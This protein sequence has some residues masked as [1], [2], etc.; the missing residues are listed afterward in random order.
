[1]N[2]LQAKTRNPDVSESH[3]ST[4][5]LA[6]PKLQQ[7]VMRVCLALALIYL[8]TASPRQGRSQ[9]WAVSGPRNFYSA[10]WHPT[11]HRALQTPYARILRGSLTLPPESQCS[12]K[13]SSKFA[14]SCQAR[15]TQCLHVSTSEM[16]SR[17]LTLSLRLSNMS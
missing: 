11:K 15:K 1:M 7:S 4:N 3:N 2:E 17:L 13:P 5:G 10:F 12:D 16:V 8:L 9:I 6:L 14:S